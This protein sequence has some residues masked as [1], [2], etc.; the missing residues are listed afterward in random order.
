[1]ELPD[2]LHVGQRVVLRISNMKADIAAAVIRKDPANRY[3]LQ[4]VMP[5]K[6]HIDLAKLG[7]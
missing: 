2:D 6:E 4:F 1:V 3:G 7:S 5:L